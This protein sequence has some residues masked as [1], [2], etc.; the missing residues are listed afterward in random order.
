MNS[1]FY[2]AL[3]LRPGLSG[4]REFSAVPFQ[5]VS[6]QFQ[7]QFSFSQFSS[8][9]FSYATKPGGPE[10]GERRLRAAQGVSRAV[11][12]GAKDIDLSAA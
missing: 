1:G 10:R 6:V 11:Q 7:Y 8:V 5:S 2:S 9:Q 12:T 3:L 4:N